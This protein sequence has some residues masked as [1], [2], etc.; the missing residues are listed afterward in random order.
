MLK[1][2]VRKAGEYLIGLSERTP[3]TEA[4]RGPDVRQFSD[5]AR[6]IASRRAP[7]DRILAGG[8]RL[9]D[10]DDIKR[11]LAL[12][13]QEVSTTAYRIVEDTIAKNLSADDSYA[14]HGDDMYVLCFASADR[15]A[16]EARMRDISDEIK[17]A[18]SGS[19]SDA[20]RIAHD[21]TDIVFVD[22]DDGPLVDTIATSLR[23]VRDE[24]E[25][26]ARVWREHLLRVASIRYKPVWSPSRKV[27]ALHRAVLD[28]ET[29][30][31]TV[32]R[33]SSLSSTDEMLAVLFELDCLILGR[34]TTGL[35]TLVGSGGRTQLIVPVNFNS[36]HLGTRRKRYLE[37]CADI[38][39]AY[40]RFILF[41]IC[42]IP[43]ATPCGRIL[44]LVVPLN[45][46]A[47]GTIV[48]APLSSAVEL[49]DGA[50]SAIVGVG[51]RVDELTGP[52]GDISARLRRL[53]MDLKAR[54]LKVFL[55]GA[56]SS[57]VVRAAITTGID[58]IDGSCIAGLTRELKT[59]YS[60]NVA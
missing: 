45:Q 40:R 43:R 17:R 4:P 44:D 41:E 50:G 58:C 46:Y 24:A 21:V 5:Q 28:E 6:R 47:R 9:L 38:P 53:V 26:A 18:L 51:T 52:V 1:S 14:R 7:E 12:N 49:I 33:L 27:V 19:A 48:E 2:I 37:L 15:E 34:S 54:N 16:V 36:L 35:H 55:H 8:I 42:N 11:E 59:L 57:D 3:A 31:R 60:W 23:K 39:S 30:Q 22:V 10:L 25:N 20:F 29:G 56:N 13:W 32:Q